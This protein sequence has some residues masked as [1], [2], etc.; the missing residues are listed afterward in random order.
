MTIAWTS[1]SDA[2][3]LDRR[4]SRN[5]GAGDPAFGGLPAGVLEG[6]GDRHSPDRHRGRYRRHAS[7][8]AVALY[9]ARRLRLQPRCRGEPGKLPSRRHRRPAGTP[10]YC[11]DRLRRRRGCWLVGRLP[12]RGAARQ[13]KSSGGQG[14]PRPA[15]ALPRHYGA[16]CCRSLRWRWARLSAAKSRRANWVRCWQRGFPLAPG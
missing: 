6:F 8:V 9:P 3:R 11:V 4:R 1:S 16:S 15:H 13:H 2:I 7:R 10:G 12:L 14:R 5:Q